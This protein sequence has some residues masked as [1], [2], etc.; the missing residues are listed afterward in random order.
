MA[1]ASIQIDSLRC[2]E[3]ARLE[4]AP[5]LTVIQ[6]ANGSGK[7]SLLE[8]LFLVGRG[9]SFRTRYTERLIRR[10][11]DRLQLYAETAAPLHRI[12]F[13]YD[14]RGTHEVRLDGR[15]PSTLAELP[16]AFF[17]EVIDPDIHRLVEGAPSER[18]RWL[19]WGVFHVEQAFLGNWTRYSRALRQRNAALKVGQDPRPWDPE[20]VQHGEAIG[21]Q[22]LAWLESLRPHWQP[23]IERLVGLPVELS[24]RPGWAST[25]SLAEALRDGLER[26]RS[27]GT[28]GDGP[29][30]A[31]VALKLGV[32]AARDVLS[33]GQQKLAASA[34]VLS[35]LE[36]LKADRRSLPTLLLDDPA[37]E[38]DA[39]R[40]DA[41]VGAVRGLECQIVLTSLA[42]DARLFGDPER[43]FHVEQG[44]VQE[45]Y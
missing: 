14:R 6:G 19:D 26:D 12:G 25:H 33:R 13:R 20:L 41:F 32:A 23:A 5:H 17:V 4:L 7:T 21:A 2:L 34:L 28:T 29:H 45:V 22:R 38:L 42:P 8:A 35:L 43:V 27:R 30:R 39:T 9:R 44:R 3:L 36:R 1:L 10:G 24:Y 40:L 18:R 11:A 37:A 15:T 16:T 31:D